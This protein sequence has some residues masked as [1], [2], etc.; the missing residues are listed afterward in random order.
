MKNSS[1]RLA[2]DEVKARLGIV[3][4]VQGFVSL[5]KSG[6]DY[7][8][9]CPFHDDKN[10]SMRVNDEKG[11]FYCFS[12]GAGGDMFGFLM[13]YNNVGFGEALRELAT[14]AGVKL[15][16]Y[17]KSIVRGKKSS[18][19][20]KFFEINS[21]VSSFYSETLHAHPTA[22]NY[23]RSRGI[24]RETAELFGLG[25]A[26]DSWDSLLRFAGENR[27][28]VEDIEKLG[29]VISREK[30]G[31][32]YDRFRNRVI[33]PIRE[34]SGKICGFGGRTISG[35]GPKQVKYINSPDSAVFDKK[36]V[37][38]GLFHSKSEIRREQKA[39]LVEG[40][41]DFIRLYSSGIRNVV[42]TLGTAFTREHAT[43]LRRFCQEV[44]IVY[45]GDDA[46]ISSAA[47]A[48]KIFLQQG[49]FPQICRIP[50]GLDPDDYI[51]KHG[52]EGLKELVDNAHSASRFIIDDTFAKYRGKKVS[53]GEAM[54]LLADTISLITDPVRRAESVTRTTEI[55]GI[56]ESDFLSMVNNS[57]PG[58]NRGSL[59]SSSAF[60]EKDIH[61][62]EIVRILL[63][64]P[65]L[66]SLEK[67]RSVSNLFRDVDLRTIVESV[68]EDDFT[69]VSSLMGSFES[70][71]MQQL[72][73]ELVISSD[74]LLDE[75][76]SGETLRG[77]L[78]KLELREIE[79][80]RNEVIESIRKQRGASDKAVE[81]ELVR[82]Y[83][84]LLKKEE[85]LKGVAH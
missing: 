12:C 53:S 18:A 35:D 33:F 77:C 1:S 59:A 6:K 16:S 43:L 20:E 72:L 70:T 41:M 29:L 73:S 51:E 38:Y 66:M 46:G 74:D 57:N 22:E 60:P 67:I 63:R 7:V 36:N 68:G 76:T 52:P 62:R 23:L 15:P 30:S 65:D 69:G 39:V 44:V 78:Q 21:R 37:L 31:G 82:Q 79:F 11:F 49:L 56:R 14:K 64:Y 13:K 55:F 26:P 80:R 45:D 3:E 81:R 48:G 54:K 34:I 75:D 10:P 5:S 19:A 4:V 24:T 17:G 61:E 42:A 83:G 47:R 84:D 9:L 32:H 2:I 40:Y 71:E 25:Y 58:K 8:G 28:D 50:E 85:H 27:I